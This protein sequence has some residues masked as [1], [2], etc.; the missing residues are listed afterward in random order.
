MVER[1]AALL[2][3]LISTVGA[4]AGGSCRSPDAIGCVA[5]HSLPLHRI[6]FICDGRHLCK[7]MHSC[8]EAYYFLEQCGVTSLDRDHDGVPCEAICG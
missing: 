1:S 7:Q 2:V 3:F 8:E 6:D 5:N 4:T